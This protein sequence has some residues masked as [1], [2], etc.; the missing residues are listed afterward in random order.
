MRRSKEQAAETKRQLLLAAEALFLE[1]GFENVTLDEIAASVGATRGALH[2]HFCNK[3]GLLCALRDKAEAPFAELADL[4][5]ASG[6]SCPL[7]RL[8]E[9]ISQSFRELH[10][11]ERRRGL[12]RVMMH[13][14]ISVSGTGPASH[15]KEPYDAMMRIFADANKRHRL[16]PP[17]TPKT[18]S[19]ALTATIHGL[20]E[21]WALDRSDLQL[22]PYG[23]EIIRNV[24]RGFV[25]SDTTSTPDLDDGSDTSSP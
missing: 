21:E 4:L 6:L 18:A 7:E 15:R 11:D 23:E 22:V 9:T 24:I 20:I 19:W 25:R 5:D 1:H 14:E 13:L 3:H 8:M 16:I 17:W 10:N 12:V 2:W